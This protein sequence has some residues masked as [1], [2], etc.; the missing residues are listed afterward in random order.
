MNDTNNFD[1]DFDIGCLLQRR[2][3]ISK[4]WVEE[5]LKNFSCGCEDL[6]R[7]NLGRAALYC[8]MFPAKHSVPVQLF[9]IT[10]FS[11]LIILSCAGN[12]AVVWIV[13]RHE[14]MRTVT[15]YYLLNLAISDLSITVLNT[16]F[17]GMYNLYYNWIFSS[18]HCAFNNLMGI[19]PICAS[20]FTMIVMSIDRYLAV[21]YP[22][23]KRPGR[24]TTVSIIVGIWVLAFVCGLP[25]LGSSDVETDKFPDGDSRTSTLFSLYN[26]SLVILQYVIPLIILSFTYGRVAYVLRQ[27]NSIGDTRHYENVQAKRRAANMLALVVFTFIFMWLP[28]NLYFIF[29]QPIVQSQM[30]FQTT[31][32]VYMNI[33]CL[34]MSSC[35]LNPVIYY[36]MNER[37]RLGF[38]YAFRWLPCVNVRKEDY[39]IVFSAGSRVS[40]PT[41]T[42]FS[43]GN[44][45]VTAHNGSQQKSSIQ[46]NGSSQHKSSYSLTQ[47]IPI[48]M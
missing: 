36:F 35:L 17:S 15:N 27:N 8:D 14:R 31:L 6:S 13:L 20:V 44:T 39:E 41:Q 24:R 43:V 18:A 47:H 23:R 45:V 3:D 28:Y 34:G 11:L 21:V 46:H 32:H 42:R 7:A 16:G 5:R 2:E 33:Y 30:D 4:Q 10:I 40:Y 22:L 12:I 25:A 29:L 37:F 9:Y 19:T 26:H 1:I 38:R 48:S